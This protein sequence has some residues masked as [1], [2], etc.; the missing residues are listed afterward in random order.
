VKADL[1]HASHY[2]GYVVHLINGIARIFPFQ[3]MDQEEVFPHLQAFFCSIVSMIVPVMPR[4]VVDYSEIN[5]R[6]GEF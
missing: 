3:R 1:S 2:L 4:Y 5:V 6:A